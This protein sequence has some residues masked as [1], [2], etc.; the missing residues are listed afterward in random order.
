[1]TQLHKYFRT[2]NLTKALEELDQ[3]G[4]MFLPLNNLEDIPKSMR[5]LSVA[6][7][8]KGIK[9]KVGKVQFVWDNNA[10]TG[11]AAEKVDK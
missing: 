3:T 7:S 5:T 4:F 6:L 2:T 10:V 8:K 9:A 11:I 1:M